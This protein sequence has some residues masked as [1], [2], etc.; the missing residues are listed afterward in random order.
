MRTLI[1]PRLHAALV[2]LVLAAAV[3]QAGPISV[4]FTTFF[5]TPACPSGWEIVAPG[6][7]VVSVVN[8]SD[9]GV[10][11][12][13]P[14]GDQEDRA[15][16][17]SAET[18]VTLPEKSIAAIADDNKQAAMHGTFPFAAALNAHG[19]GYPFTQL[20]LCRYTGTAGNFSAGFGTV[21][22]FTS[23]VNRCPAGWTASVGYTGRILMPGFGEGGAVSNSA[24]P[25]TSGEDRK[26]THVYATSFETTPVAF[27]GIA[28]CC[29]R[30]PAGQ[31]TVAVAGTS[32]EAST[33]LPYLQMLTCTNEEPTFE[34]SMP[35][36]ALLF[37]ELRCPPGWS[38]TDTI[39]GRMLASLPVG[40]MPG[41][42]FGGSSIEPGPSPPTPVHD[43][44]VSGNITLPPASVMLDS[45]G[46]AHGYAKTAT[47]SVSAPSHDAAAGLPYTMLP[48]CQQNADKERNQQLLRRRGNN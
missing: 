4:G 36:G 27:A 10:T 48:M 21:A 34:A 38:I 46:D 16:T 5:T 28:G 7:V 25:L 9:A 29:N 20:P 11:V 30:Q 31:G 33:G 19:S 37:H 39:A 8:M 43:H 24:P 40:G 44:I 41:A 2:A 12:N 26:H 32:S 14:L 35:P 15:H 3:A 1:S 13:Q 45:G 47:Y 23:D 18:T 6:R 42:S 17:H 22:H